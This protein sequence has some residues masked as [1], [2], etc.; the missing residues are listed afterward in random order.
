MKIAGHEVELDHVD[1]DEK[2]GVGRV[3]VY[4]NEDRPAFDIKELT[5]LLAFLAGVQRV[6][7]PNQEH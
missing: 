3:I 1:V 7:T 2:T 4:I 5:E 6:F